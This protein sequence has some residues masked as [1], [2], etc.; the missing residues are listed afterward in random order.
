MLREDEPK[1]QPLDQ[2][3]L[4]YRVDTAGMIFDAFYG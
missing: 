4:Q 1:R 2:D 3:R